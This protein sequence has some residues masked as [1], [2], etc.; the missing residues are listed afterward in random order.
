MGMQEEESRCRKR[1]CAGIRGK[2]TKGKSKTTHRFQTSNAR[3]P[4]PATEKRINKSAASVKIED[5]R[6]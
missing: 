3:L 1:P 6:M 2:E 4:L 5:D